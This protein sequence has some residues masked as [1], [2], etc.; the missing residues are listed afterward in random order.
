MLS[1]K[2]VEVQAVEGIEMFMMGDFDGV[3]RKSDIWAD[4][5]LQANDRF[6]GSNELLTDLSVG[7]NN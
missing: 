3:R 6:E 7:T 2:V 4:N 5:I 1:D